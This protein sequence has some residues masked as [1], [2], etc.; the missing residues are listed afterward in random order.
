MKDLEYNKL[1]AGLLVAGIIAM[2]TGMI[3]DGF[4]STQDLEKDAFPIKASSGSASSISPAKDVGPAPITELLAAVDIEKGKKAA[5]ACLSC[6]SFNKGGPNGTGPN[7]YDIVNR[8]IAA[9]TSFS[10]SNA[11]AAKSSENWTYEELN[12]FLFKPKKHIAGTKMSYAGIKK[13][14]IRANLIAWLGTLSDNPTPLPVAE[15]AIESTEE[16]PATNE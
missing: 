11:M 2:T 4:V 8:P 12:K 7:L 5:N 9:S 10:Y 1:L 14:S 13:D 6:H 16:T 3:A 15:A